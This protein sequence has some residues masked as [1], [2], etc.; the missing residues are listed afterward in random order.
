[1]KSAILRFLNDESGATAMEYA[2]T[3]ALIGIVVIAAVSK[4]GSNL[5]NKFSS[6][7]NNVT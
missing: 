7:A 3:G 2:L 6:M 1:M 5:S 4:L